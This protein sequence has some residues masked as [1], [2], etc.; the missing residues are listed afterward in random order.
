MNQDLK[1]IENIVIFCQKPNYIKQLSRY[2]ETN[3]AAIK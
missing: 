1:E 2:E 3:K